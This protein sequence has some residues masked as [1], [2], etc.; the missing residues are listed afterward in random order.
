MQAKIFGSALH[1]MEAFRITIEVSVDR[2]LGVSI[3]GLP[4]DGIKE[5]YNR[6]AVAVSAN[7]Y[8]MPRTKLVINLAP[9]DVRKT[10]TAFDLPI[11]IGILIASEQ[12]YDLGKLKDYILIGELGLD[13]SLRPVRGALCMAYQAKLDGYKG[14]VLPIENAKEAAMVKGINTYAVSSLEDVISFIKSD[15]ALEPYRPVTEVSIFNHAFDFSVVKGQHSARRALEIAAAGGHNALLIGPPGTGKTLLAKCFP[16][17]LPPMTDTE[18]LET[19]RIHS[20]SSSANLLR[21]LVRE[22][23]F[24]SPHHTSSDVSLIGGGSVPMPGAIS[25][26]HNGVL[27]LD[28]LGEFRRNVIEALRQP[29]EDRK[30]VISRAKLSLEYPASFTLLAAMNPCI[31]GYDGHPTRK[32]SCSKRALWWYRRKLSGPLLDRIDLHIG[33]EPMC[34]EEL[35]QNGEPEESSATIRKRV[36]KARNIQSA[37]FKIFP[38]VHC[39][40][41]MPEA[42]L[43]KFCEMEEYAKRFLYKQMDPMQLSARSY[44][45]I[46]KISRT[47]ADLEG[48]DI[49]E[50]ADV[51]EAVHYRSL[52]KPVEQS[53]Q[54]IRKVV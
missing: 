35:M 22:R 17:I 29:L 10:G 45:R 26:A 25:M 39:N 19:T 42:E 37:R 32:C 15:A 5:S 28:E 52:D 43:V 20:V 21:G 41:Q 36:I 51:A 14:I 18:A 44:S 49:L 47:I 12:L 33:A 13:G 4:D 7:G 34:L 6:I 40:A 24:I 8:Q 54:P 27:F 50:L 2:G 53:V 9:A 23:P 38:G 46:L 3:T 30:V 31:C 11:A 1:G 48:R 16:S